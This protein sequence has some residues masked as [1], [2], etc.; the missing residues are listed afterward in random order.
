MSATPDAT[1]YAAINQVRNRSG[2][3]NL[4]AGLPQAAFRDSVI[5]E[6]GWEFA[7][8]EPAARWYDLIR[9]ETVAKANSDRD[10]SE[11]ALKNIPNDAAHTY[12]WAPIPVGDKQLNPNL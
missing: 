3:A 12:Y 2:L 10:V 7:G 6:R 9:T 4:V 1:A 8:A 5:A 11:E